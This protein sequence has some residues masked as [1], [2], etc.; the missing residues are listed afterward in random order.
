M[1]K[2]NKKMKRKCIGYEFL[3]FAK[4]TKCKG[5]SWNANK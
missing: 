5:D 1:S 4:D 3:V 2:L